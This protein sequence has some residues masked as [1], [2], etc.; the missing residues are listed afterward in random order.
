MD[1]K[2]DEQLLII[3]ATIEATR[4]D[5]DEKMNKLTEDFKAI[6]T[7]TIASIM[8]HISMSKSSTDYND[9]P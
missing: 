3:Q 2:S 4:Q 1:N 6:I 8:D 7:S 9:S 5:S